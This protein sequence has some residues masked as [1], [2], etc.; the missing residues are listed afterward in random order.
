MRAQEK[1]AQEKAAAVKPSPEKTDSEKPAASPI[2]TAPQIRRAIAAMRAG[3]W[4]AARGAWEKVLLVEPENP[5]ALSNLGKVL[6]QLED[7]PAAQTTLE[8]AT[9]LKPELV[10]SWLTLG[11][12]YLSRKAPMMAVSSM[13]RGVSE[14]PADPRAHN[15][16][17]IVLKRVGWTDGAEAE[18]QKA[19]DL[20][21]EYS[22]AHFNLALMYLE[23]KPPSL[24]MANRHYR[25]ACALGA[26]PDPLVEKQLQG[27]TVIAEESPE[28]QSAS[29]PDS[30]S[31]PSASGS[32]SKSDSESETST[33]AAAAKGRE[34]AEAGSKSATAPASAT[35]PVPASAPDAPKKSSPRQPPSPPKK[36]SRKS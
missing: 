4:K 7:Y 23:R 20:N 31:P 29:E 24:E 10:D 19:L 15:S 35:K 5:A 12:T 3:E 21:P 13:T 25:R 28:P 22:E 26:E 9:T 34:A 8:K 14:N 36:S 16:L 11:L 1:P 17:A 2:D 27:E 32:G 18:L 33:A 6:Y 30:T